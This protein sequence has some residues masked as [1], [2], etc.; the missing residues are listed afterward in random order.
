MGV[1]A[2]SAAHNDPVVRHIDFSNQPN[3]RAPLGALPV[4]NQPVPGRAATKMESVRHRQPPFASPDRPPPPTPEVTATARKDEGIRRAALDQ[5]CGDAVHKAVASHLAV[6]ASSADLSISQLKN[7][8][9]HAQEI[10]Q[11]STVELQAAVSELREVHQRQLHRARRHREAPRCCSVVNECKEGDEPAMEEVQE[12]RVSDHVH[13]PIRE[14]EEVANAPPPATPAFTDDLKEN[15]PTPATSQPDS[16]QA[17]KPPLRAPAPLG[18]PRAT[19]EAP[20]PGCNVSAV[21]RGI[22]NASAFD[23]PEFVRAYLS[24]RREQLAEQRVAAEEM[25][26]QFEELLARQRELRDG[27]LDGSVCSG[28]VGT[29]GSRSSRRSVVRFSDAE[30]KSDV[31][32]MRLPLTPE[33]LCA[34]EEDAGAIAAARAIEAIANAVA[35]EECPEALRHRVCELM[36]QLEDERKHTK[37]MLCAQV[38]CPHCEAFV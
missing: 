9:K 16:T 19:P 35:P 31:V 10:A 25:G 32:P 20:T 18:P 33:E 21:V 8:Q 37:R 23:G 1:A 30:L 14:D 11:S 17:A 36:S 26:A 22:D 2:S 12:P 29:V 3:V 34:V 38:V 24:V 13:D 27:I 7:L 5:L 15:V 4:N 6:A 28:S